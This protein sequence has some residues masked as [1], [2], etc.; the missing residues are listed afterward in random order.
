VTTGYRPIDLDEL[1]RRVDRAATEWRSGARC[2]EIESLSGGQSSLTFVARFDG[3][4]DP[5]VLKVAPPGLAPVRNRDVLRQ[6]RVLRAMMQV[7]GF[8]VPQVLFEDAGHPPDVPPFVAMSHV[9]G[10]SFEPHLDDEVEDVDDAAIAGRAREAARLLALLHVQDP[11]RLGLGTEPVTSIEQEIDRWERAFGTVTGLVGSRGATAI[12]AVRRSIPA[13]STACI[14]HGD[15]RL[16]NMLSSHDS[17]NAVIDWEIWS[18]ADP[19]LDLS[20]FLL[21]CDAAANPT[22][23]RSHSGVPPVGE[24]LDEYVAAGG[25][26]PIALAWFQALAL[27]KMAATTALI[28]K[29]NLRIGRTDLVDRAVPRLDR[30][31]ASVGD[32]LAC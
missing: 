4:G 5:L 7:P 12:A 3:V 1:A 9:A 15:F 30:M 25:R 24:L 23:V 28:A 18:R 21:C 13:E 19:R 20:W 8:K 10:R 31:L 14:V 22:A 11:Q 6:G 27:T 29:H 16:G 32:A 26:P 17:V 2:V